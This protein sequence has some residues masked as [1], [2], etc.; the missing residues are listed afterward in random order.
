MGRRESDEGATHRV[1]DAPGLPPVG[2]P[3]LSGHWA[4]CPAPLAMPPVHHDVD[5]FDSSHRT[6]E[7]L[8]QTLIAAL[9]HDQQ[10]ETG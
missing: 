9:D 10:P 4:S 3:T 5:P 6:R 8:V 2:L 1:N 7:V